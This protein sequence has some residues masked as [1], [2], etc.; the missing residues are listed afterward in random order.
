M[1]HIERKRCLSGGRLF[2]RL[3]MTNFGLDEVMAPIAF[4]FAA[5]FRDMFEVR[6]LR[7][8]ARG[9]MRAAH[10]DGRGVTLRYDGLDGIQRTSVIAFSEPPWRITA[11]RADFMF[12]LMPDR[13]LDLFVEVAPPAADPPDRHRFDAALAAARRPVESFGTAAPAWSRRTAVSA[14][15]S[16]NR[17]RMSPC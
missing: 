17:A 7:R 3:R 2:E 16:T 9:K 13:R 4:E 11:A 6:G 15:G 1:I 8:P 14:P 5:D 10:S 12:T